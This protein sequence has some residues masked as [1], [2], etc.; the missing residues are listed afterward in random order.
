VFKTFSDLFTRCFGLEVEEDKH[1]K[2][3]RYAMSM[4]KSS[5]VIVMRGDSKEEAA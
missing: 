3:K 2:I 5:S 4:Q 1:K